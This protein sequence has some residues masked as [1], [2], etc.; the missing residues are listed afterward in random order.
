MQRGEQMGRPQDGGNTPPLVNGAGAECPNVQ[1]NAA[2]R[3]SQT[4]G[5]KRSA[6]PSNRGG[7]EAHGFNRNSPPGSKSNAGARSM[8]AGIPRCFGG[9]PHGAAPGRVLD[10]LVPAHAVLLPD[11]EAQDRALRRRGRRL[12][13]DLRVHWGR[14][15]PPSGAARGTVGCWRDV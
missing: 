5:P 12:R 4:H 7:I 15:P 9:H 11:L 2:P 3:N 10:G 1:A 8:E 13:G 6:R 14:R